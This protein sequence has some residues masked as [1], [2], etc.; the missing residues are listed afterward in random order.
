MGAKKEIEA[1]KS[2][3]KALTRYEE[4]IEVESKMDYVLMRIIKLIIFYVMPP[5]AFFEKSGHFFSDKTYRKIRACRSFLIYHSIYINLLFIVYIVLNLHFYSSQNM[6]IKKIH[7]INLEAINFHKNRMDLVNRLFK[8]LGY[9]YYGIKSYMTW[10]F[11][12]DVFTNTCFFLFCYSSIGYL[13]PISECSA[14]GFVLEPI[15]KTEI[16][17]TNDDI[18]DHLPIQWNRKKIYRRTILCIFKRT[19]TNISFLIYLSIFFGQF[20]IVESLN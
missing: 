12:Y 19:I 17:R 1:E 6:I 13:N 16:C 4:K 11:A 14:F 15:T 5:R 20:K 10:S 7:K 18:I 9:P 8:C 2:N 3:G